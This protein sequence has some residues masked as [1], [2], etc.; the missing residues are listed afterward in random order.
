LN[1]LIKTKGQPHNWVT[2]NNT[3]IGNV[4]SLGL[5]SEPGVLNVNKL[6]RL[7]EMPYTSA[8]RLLGF[9]KEGFHIEVISPNN[10]TLYSIGEPEA[11]GPISLERMALF[12]NLTIKFRL[13]VFE[14]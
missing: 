14:T 7:S 13:R 9:G 8:R 12:D 10:M 1:L 2:L 11:E 5:V 4:T 3:D 6:E